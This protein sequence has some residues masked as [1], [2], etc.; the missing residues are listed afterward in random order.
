MSKL[1]F[2]WLLVI[3]IISLGFLPYKLPTFN[4]QLG[5][6]NTLLVYHE[7]CTCCG[8]FY[9]ED[10]ELEI[11]N[12]LKKFFPN[13]PKELTTT[14]YSELNN[15]NY[16]LKVGSKFILK[17]RITGVD[18]TEGNTQT[19][20]CQIRPIFYIDNWQPTEYKLNI[21]TFSPPYFI[22]Y[23]ITLFCSIIYAIII[24]INRK[25]NKTQ[26]DNQNV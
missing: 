23:F 16:E 14:K 22:L 18:S 13:N 24:T 6:K 15:L 5:N 11:P 8:D 20:D 12:E 26:S 7:E 25:K 10:G 4:N 19:G 2:I 3:L 21:W 9:I 17:G 1:I